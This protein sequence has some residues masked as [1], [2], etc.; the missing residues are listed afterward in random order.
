MVV[1]FKSP[2]KFNYETNIVKYSSMYGG[3]YKYMTIPQVFI[4]TSEIINNY[5]QRITNT[6]RRQNIR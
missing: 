6:L 3:G 1:L 2:I 5:L 4:S